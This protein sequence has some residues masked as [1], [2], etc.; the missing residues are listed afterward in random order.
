[1]DAKNLTISNFTA[2][3]ISAMSQNQLR[4]VVKYLVAELEK[5]NCVSEQNIAL[6]KQILKYKSNAEGT[7]FLMKELNKLKK[8][9]QIRIDFSKS[10]E[11]KQK[12]FVEQEKQLNQVTK[13]RDILSEQLKHHKNECFVMKKKNMDLE[14]ALSRL[15]KELVEKHVYEL[16]VEK[17][18]MEKSN[19][20]SNLLLVKNYKEELVQ[21]EK[22]LLKEK[23]RGADLEEQL[24]Q[25]ITKLDNLPPKIAINVPLDIS[26]DVRKAYKHNL[27]LQGNVT[28]TQQLTIKC[29]QLEK[30][31]QVIAEKEQQCE[32]LKHRLSRMFPPERLELIPKLQWEIRAQSKNIR[33][34]M[35]QVH[36]WQIKAEEYK[37]ENEKLVDKVA[38]I[39]KLYLNERMHYTDLREAL[40]RSGAKQLPEDKSGAI[41]VPPSPSMLHKQSGE[42]QGHT[43]MQT[44]KSNPVCFPPISNKFQLEHDVGSAHTPTPTDTESKIISSYI[45]LPAIS[46]K[47]LQM[48]SAARQTKIFMTQS[49]NEQQ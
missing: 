22:D 1:M 48:Q 36:M 40:K 41:Q 20:E 6:K 25:A 23:R 30:K 2:A 7:E 43:K 5:M 29:R 45:H 35:A 13:Q 38:A 26:R 4:N 44:L 8:N 37:S 16:E 39:K 11:D 17:L 33:A 3:T 10:L 18:Q 31:D 21:K 15:E 24:E 12:Y 27:Q 49:D 46:N 47:S 34:L 9:L 19:L 42:K 14:V 28:K 32:E